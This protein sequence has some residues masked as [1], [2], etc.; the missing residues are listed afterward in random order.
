[1]KIS[2]AQK[3]EIFRKVKVEVERPSPFQSLFFWDP[4]AGSQYE[5]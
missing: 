4:A 5:L 3:V 2:P 1:M